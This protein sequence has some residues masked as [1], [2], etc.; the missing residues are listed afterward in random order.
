MKTPTVEYN[1]CKAPNKGFGYMLVAAIIFV[2]VVVSLTSIIEE[3]NVTPAHYNQAV[4]L[5]EPNKGLKHFNVF[6][7]D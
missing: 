1:K 2:F 4:Q 3:R 6:N 5:C 7:N